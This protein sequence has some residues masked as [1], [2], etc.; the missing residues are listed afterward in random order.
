MIRDSDRPII[1]IWLYYSMKRRIFK[2]CAVYF[3][4][5]RSLSMIERAAHRALSKNMRA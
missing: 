3:G 1:L 2:G 4:F 5:C